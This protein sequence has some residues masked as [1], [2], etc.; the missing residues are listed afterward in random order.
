MKTAVAVVVGISVA[1]VLL[2]LVRLAAVRHT[3]EP[4]P[5]D[6]GATVDLPERAPVA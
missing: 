2:T 3:S 5:L 6:L 1:G 4:V